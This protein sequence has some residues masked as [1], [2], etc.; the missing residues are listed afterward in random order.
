MSKM[1]DS[2]NPEL[3][4]IQQALREVARR[5]AVDPDFRKLAV[6]DASAA[7]AKVHNKPLPPDYTFRF[8]DNSGTVKTIPLPDPVTGIEELSEAEL[9][10]VAGGNIAVTWS[11]H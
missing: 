9:E 11:K 2:P 10:Q 6:K 8:V 3:T 7:I 4:E 1:T 5:S